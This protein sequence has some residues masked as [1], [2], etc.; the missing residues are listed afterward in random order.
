ME[1]ST[2]LRLTKIQISNLIAIDSTLTFNSGVLWIILQLALIDAA[3][4]YVAITEVCCLNRHNWIFSTEI[5]PFFLGSEVLTNTLIGYLL[6]CFNFHV[7]S[8]WN[9]HVFERQ[10]SGKNPLT[11]YNDES[12]ECL[13]SKAENRN[14]TIDYRKRKHDVSVIFPVI[15]VWFVGLSLSVP[16]FTLS[17]TLKYNKRFMLCTIIDVYYGRL[18]QILLVVFRVIIPV[19]LFLLSGVIVA[20][21]LCQSRRLEKDVNHV[22]TKKAF[23]IE[24]FLVFALVLSL[25]HISSSFQREL[26][27]LMHVFKQPTDDISAFMTPPLYNSYL[28]NRTSTYLSMLNYIASTTRPFLYLFLLPKFKNF[29]RSKICAKAQNKS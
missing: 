9:L 28:S 17:S 20:I 15:L 12:N 26:F 24:A 19:P 29:I 16:E 21:K 13:V 25:T 22:L 10:K 27:Y 1:L 8:L 14:V 23:K 3:S 18:L 7:I 4:V 11:T 2:I 6:I 5:C